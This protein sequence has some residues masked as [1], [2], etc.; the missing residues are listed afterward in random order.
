MS[1]RE[2]LSRHL[3]SHFTAVDTERLARYGTHRRGKVRDLFVGDDEIIM[4]TSD[5]LSAFDVVLTSIPCTSN[6]S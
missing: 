1:R 2:A 4:V 6:L 5:R 3:H